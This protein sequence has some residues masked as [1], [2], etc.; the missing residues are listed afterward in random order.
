MIFYTQ[1]YVDMSIRG[2]LTKY[3]NIQLRRIVN[4]TT[5]YPPY[6]IKVLNASTNYKQ[7]TC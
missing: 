4:K 2:T 3:K 1:R 5:E 6:N 7:T